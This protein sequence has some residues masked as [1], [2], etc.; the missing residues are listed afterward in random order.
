MLFEDETSYE[1]TFADAGVFSGHGTLA[2]NNGDR[3]EG[4]FYGN[5]TEGM[6]FSGTIYKSGSAAKALNLSAVNKEKVGFNGR[7]Q[8]RGSCQH[9]YMAVRSV[10]TMYTYVHL[11]Q[12]QI[13]SYSARTQEPSILSKSTIIHFP[14]LIQI[15][16]PLSLSRL[17]L[18]AS[19]QTK[20]G[21]PYTRT[22]TS[23]SACP[24]T[25]PTPSP[26]PPPPRRASS[27]TASPSSSTR[28]RTPTT[29]PPAAA[30]SWTA[31][32]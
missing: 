12:D 20:S 14:V 26:F 11:Y 29:L 13:V 25:T 8:F 3:L 30:T 1:G 27:G 5:Y 2:Y 21:Y 10:R 18:F 4:S 19:P 6:K 31:S 22:T 24:T 23:S 15:G 17:A 28:P 32:R 9:A 16:H 7:L